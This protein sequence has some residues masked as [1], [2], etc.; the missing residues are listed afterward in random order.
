MVVA[1]PK[2]RLPRQVINRLRII[3]LI[4]KNPS[5]GNGELNRISGMPHSTFESALAWLVKHDVVKKNPGRGTTKSVYLLD[6]KAFEK[7]FYAHFMRY[8]YPIEHKSK[9]RREIER[10]SF[11]IPEDKFSY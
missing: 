10:A 3:S 2:P 8:H 4:V 1:K 5:M 6:P 9:V 11:K 7:H